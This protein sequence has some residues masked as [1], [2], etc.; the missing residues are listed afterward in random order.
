[1]SPLSPFV[2]VFI[3]FLFALCTLA[4][5]VGLLVI[6]RHMSRA[7]DDIDRNLG[8]VFCILLASLIAVGAYGVV[9]VRSPRGLAQDADLLAM[10]R[11]KPLGNVASGLMLLALGVGIMLYT[12][13]PE[14]NDRQFVWY[15]AMAVGAVQA[16]VGASQFAMAKR[17]RRNPPDA[18]ADSE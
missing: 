12:G 5:A 13:S 18:A 9:Y 14:R 7:E 10:A 17:R 1:M 4:G 11:S 2:R 3:Q 15:G 6:I 16:L 8:W